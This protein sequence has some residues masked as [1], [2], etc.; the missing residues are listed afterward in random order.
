MLGA[1]HLPSVYEKFA[2]NFGK[3]KAVQKWEAHACAAV[4][5]SKLTG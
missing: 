1:F 5:F 2:L 4:L 3:Y